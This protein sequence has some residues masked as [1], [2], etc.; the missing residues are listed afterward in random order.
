M[1]GLSNNSK[2][3]RGLWRGRHRDAL[4][5]RT[6][7]GGMKFHRVRIATLSAAVVCVNLLSMPARALTPAEVYK[8]AGP[9]V[10][11]LLGSDNGKSGAGGTGSIISSDGKLITNAHV[12]LNAAGRPYKTIYV[13]LKPPRLT[14]EPRRD[15]A[16]RYTARVMAFS[17]AK[18]LD[19][20][21][22]QIIKAPR[23]LP[24]IAFA[25]PDRVQIGDEA[26]AI[27]HPEQGGL[28]TLTTGVVSTV[29]ANY[30]GVSG[31]NV[32]QTE[33]SVNRGNSG[34][35]LLDDRGA[36]IGINTM[37]AR[38]GSG[39][40]TITD[41]NFALKSSVAVTWLAGQGMGLAYARPPK[42]GDSQPQVMV[43]VAPDPHVHK[44][45]PS[46]PPTTAPKLNQVVSAKE[47][48]PATIVVQERPPKR[49]AQLRE[50]GKSLGTGRAEEKVKAGHRL[51]IKKAKPTY[52]TKKRPM[53]LD[54][55]RRQQMREMDDLLQDMRG[56]F[57]RKRRH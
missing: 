35:P 5:S 28:W 56:K 52:L 19:L 17:P 26:V 44:A 29:I 21:L 37:I 34:G 27:G 36:M 12:V 11:L 47:P 51:D 6:F 8:Q 32:F 54:D 10:V 2:F 18:E 9:A 46:L 45:D 3:T 48:P 53:S 40:L 15:L 30:G 31:K 33:A 20:A 23:D 38:R 16:N 49:V 57:N 22:L 13:F 4:C 24:T 7:V 14:G 41:I 55:L 50:E 1:S 39:G 42:S 43:A 25:D